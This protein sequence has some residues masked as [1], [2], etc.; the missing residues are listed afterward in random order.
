MEKKSDAFEERIKKVVGSQSV[1]SFGEKCGLSDGALRKYLTGRSEPGL[2]ALKSISEAA[3][4]EIKWLATGEGPMRVGDPSSSGASVDA[5]ILRQAM[6]TV[7]EA[8]EFTGKTMPP[9]KKA[10]LVAAIYEY[11]DDENE[12]RGKILKLIKTAI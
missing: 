7:E 2:S 6:E 10:A 11:F 12:D 8:L 3:G 1:R 5:E 9:A 4:V